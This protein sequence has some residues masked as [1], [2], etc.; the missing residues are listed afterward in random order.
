VES[1][2]LIVDSLQ[3]GGCFRSRIVAVPLVPMSAYHQA[4]ADHGIARLRPFAVGRLPD[5]LPV[6]DTAGQGE[7]A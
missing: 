2:P 3:E 6:P 4:P 1:L 5:V 7:A